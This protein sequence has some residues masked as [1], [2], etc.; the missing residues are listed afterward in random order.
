MKVK[1]NVKAG[2]KSGEIMTADFKR[3]TRHNESEEPGL[4]PGFPF[5]I[6]HARQSIRRMTD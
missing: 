1:T 6:G 2:E 5:S 3:Q 4:S